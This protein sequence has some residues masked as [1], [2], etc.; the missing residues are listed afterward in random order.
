MTKKQFLHHDN[1]SKY[2][3]FDKYSGF[4]WHDSLGGHLKTI[5]EYPNDRYSKI[6][7]IHKRLIIGMRKL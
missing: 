6:F 4:D 5:E 1:Q 2:S 7:A 3:I